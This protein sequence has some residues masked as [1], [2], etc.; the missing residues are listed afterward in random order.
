MAFANIQSDFNAIGPPTATPTCAF[1]SNVGAGRLLIGVVGWSSSTATCTVADNQ[2]GS[3]TA[4]GSPQTGTGGL[5]NLRL[6]GFYFIGSASGATT[7]TATLSASLPNTIIAIHEYSYGATPS[8]DGTPAY[9]TGSGVTHTTPAV[10]TTVTDALVFAAAINEF[11]FTGVNA[12]FTLREVSFA[13][14]DDVDAGAAGSKSATFT[15]G[16]NLPNI[17]F[18]LAFKEEAAADTGLAWIRA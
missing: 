6:Q 8:V 16:A 15:G 3:W 10:T 17:G 9:N 7:V 1:G 13:T 5:A 11:A 4:V 2:N 14:G 18:T 12:P